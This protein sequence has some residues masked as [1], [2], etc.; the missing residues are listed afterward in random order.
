MTPSTPSAGLYVGIDVAKDKLDMARSDIADVVTVANDAAGIHTILRQ[1]QPLA[2]Q[3]IVVESTGGIERALLDAMLDA[4]LPVALVNPGHVRYF[5]KAVGRSAKTDAID[6]RILAEFGRVT[7]PRLL[8]KR[9]ENQAEL[10]ALVTCRRQ[11]SHAQTEHKNRRHGTRSKAALKSI[12]AVLKALDT[13]IDSLN[14]QIAKLIESDDDFKDID[15]LLKT[16]PGVG[17]VLSATLLAELTELGKTDRRQLG[18][19]VGVAP[20][21]ND[22]GRHSGKRTIRGGRNDVRSVLYMSAL[23]AIRHNPV[24]HT[25]A[26]R[27]KASGKAPKVV[28]VAAMRKLLNLLNAMIRENL[29][30]EQ[31]NV[32]KNP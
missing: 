30:W 10:E 31:L 15:R 4:G 21:N 13:Q 7:A 8:A 5:A 12:D 24:I 20:F 19:L 17:V 23:S 22:S 14:R 6:A 1:L 28:I 9:S 2:V 26:E 16:V 29:T 25:F 32:V 11:L 27:L 3:V 18:A